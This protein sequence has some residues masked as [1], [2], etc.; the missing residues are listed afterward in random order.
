M[1]LTSSIMM[2]LTA[3]LFLATVLFV[4]AYRLPQAVSATALLVLIPIQPVDTRYASANVLLTF[5][6]F[7]AMLMK[8]EKVRLPLLPQ[9]LILLFCYLLS[10]SFVHKALYLQHSVYIVAL[11]SSY[12]VLCIAYDLTLRYQGFN[13]VVNVLLAMNLVTVVYCAVQMYGGPGIKLMVFGLE[14]MAMLPA[15]DD[16]RLLGPFNATGVTSEFFVIMIFLILHRLLLT[17]NVRLRYG[18]ISLTFV[19]LGMLV[20]TGNRGGFLSLLGGSVLFLWLFRRELGVRNVVRLATSGTIMLALSAA[21]VVN[22]TD[23]GRLFERLSDTTVEEGVPDTRQ[24]AWPMAWENIKKRPMLGQGP[25]LVMDGANKGA[26]YPGWKYQG[27]PHNLYL[28]LATTIGVI[29]LI[30][31]LFFF[32]TPLVRCWKTSKQRGLVGDEATFVKLGVLVFVVILIDQ[33]KVEFM[34]IGL[35]DYWHFVFALLGIFTAACDRVRVADRN[36]V[37]VSSMRALSRNAQI[38]QP[39]HRNL[40][41]S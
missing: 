8:G 29:G 23:F 28:F 33:L 36:G 32:T 9:F 38:P 17:R 37:L 4:I 7:V 10:M 15:R 14:E 18:L 13:R 3:L 34:R 27:Y 40:H 1:P 22:Y 20:A 11:I 24:K 2:Q 5:V 19:N 35:V 26:T 16:N 21:L 30:A 39:K 31:F 25:R 6:I 12:M 41:G